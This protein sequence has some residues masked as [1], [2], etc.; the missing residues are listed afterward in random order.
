[1]PNTLI[2]HGGGEHA[3][4]VIDAIKKCEIP[5]KGVFDPKFLGIVDGIN[6]LGKYDPYEFPESKAIVSIGD[7]YTRKKAVS[8]MSH[9][10]DTVIHP[11]VILGSEVNIGV[12]CMVLHGAIVQVGAQ[13]LNHVIINT[14]AQIDHDCVIGEY[15]HIAPRAVLCGT[16]EVAEGCLIGAGATLLPGVKVGKWSVVGAG[17]VVLKNVPEYTVVAGSPARVIRRLD[18]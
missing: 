14:G 2:L 17:S 3:R 11:S 6:F 1:M 13:L 16:V 4:V 15:V 12:G 18:I 9:K 5:L 8:L 10:F 7:N